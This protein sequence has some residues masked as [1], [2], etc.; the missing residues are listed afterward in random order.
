VASKIKVRVN[1]MKE[2]GTR[3]KVKGEREMKNEVK[4][5]RE[6]VKEK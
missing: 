4:G 6:K 5:A 1:E 3:S 2:L